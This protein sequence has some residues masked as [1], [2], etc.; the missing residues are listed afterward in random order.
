[1]PRVS[2]AEGEKVLPSVFDPRQTF[3]RF[4]DLTGH[5]RVRAG[6]SPPFACQGH[7]AELLIPRPQRRAARYGMP[8]SIATK[9]NGRLCSKY[10]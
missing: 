6:I 5:R 7:E 9:R 3:D 8:A 10:G 2:V 1:M 4:S